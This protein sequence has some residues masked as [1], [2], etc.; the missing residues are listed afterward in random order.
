MK[1]LEVT[2]CTWEPTHTLERVQAQQ[3]ALANGSIAKLIRKFGKGTAEFR[4]ALSKLKLMSTHKSLDGSLHCPEC[5]AL[6]DTVLATPGIK[7][8]TEAIRDVAEDFNK[9]IERTREARR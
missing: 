2:V 1:S 3:R 5:G 8:K 6:M 7:D 9:A 4:Q